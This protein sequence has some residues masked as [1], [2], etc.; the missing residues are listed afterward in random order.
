[1]SNR[2]IIVHPSCIIREGL[3]TIIRQTFDL[4]PLL[5]SDVHE[6][7]NYPDIN[8]CKLLF[9]VASDFNKDDIRSRIEYYK[10]SNTARLVLIR[11]KDDISACDDSCSCCF[12]TNS[13]MERIET[14]IRPYLDLKIN[15]PEKTN[16]TGLTERE[17]DVLKL[18][19][20]GKTNKEIAD[21]LYI[22]I[23]TVISHR[24]NITEK[25]GIKSISGL[26]VYAILNNLIDTKTIDP[27]SLI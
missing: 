10:S 19:A 23:H 8:G 7:N 25:L 16:H 9:L 17:I 22:S 5:L 20:F 27:E 2:V 1:M 24:K 4:E 26:T 13:G 18:I 14:V 21:E 11:E 3:S 6:L 15:R 12:Y